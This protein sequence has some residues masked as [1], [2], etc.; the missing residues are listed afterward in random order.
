MIKPDTIQIRETTCKSVVNRSRIPGIDYSVNPYL[1]CLHGC[2]YCYARFMTRF[3]KQSA[4]WGRFL[5]IKT[6]APQIAEKQLIRL[7]RGLVSLST[8]TDPYQ[9]AEKRYGLTREILIRL[10]D[11]GFPVSILTKSGLVIRDLDILKRFPEEDLEVGFS[12]ATMDESVRK[13]LE[14]G[15]PPAAGRIEALDMLH[16]CGIRTWVFIAPVLP[17]ITQ[18]DLDVLLN[19]IQNKT[20]KVLVDRLYIKC[21]NWKP[22]IQTLNRHRPDL[23]KRY[24]EIL[25][26]RSAARDYFENLYAQIEDLCA[27]RRI[28]VEFC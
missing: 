28:P 19:A 27:S 22:I 11:H 18:L 9:A 26:N 1:G 15:A 16:R 4:P 24:R 14:P 2:V 17:L 21:G 7:N 10:A 25:F 6:N 8:V 12:I 3:A 20:D 13:H 23:V 5:E